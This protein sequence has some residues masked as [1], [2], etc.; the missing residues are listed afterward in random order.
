[1]G[2]AHPP[3]CHCWLARQCLRNTWL[4]S[5]QWHPMHEVFW[6]ARTLYVRATRPE[7]AFF[8]KRTGIV[9][10]IPAQAGIQWRRGAVFPRPEVERY[11]L[12]G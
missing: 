6:V 3:G 1:M 2:S 10:V 7:A 12:A 8:F 11:R 5:Q 4:A 9:P